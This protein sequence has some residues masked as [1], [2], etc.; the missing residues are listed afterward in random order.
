MKS[1]HFSCLASR[2]AAGLDKV[3]DD[4]ED[5][6]DYTREIFEGVPALE[7]AQRTQPSVR[8]PAH[9]LISYSRKNTRQDITR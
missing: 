4:F 3:V 9:S 8:H 6:N 2:F 5:F 7:G 1:M